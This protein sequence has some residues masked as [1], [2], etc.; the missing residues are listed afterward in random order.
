MCHSHNIKRLREKKE[1]TLDPKAGGP[2]PLLVFPPQ[3][4][5]PAVGVALWLSKP[6]CAGTGAAAVR[7]CSA[8]KLTNESRWG[9]LSNNDLQGLVSTWVWRVAT[10]V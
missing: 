10:E 6:E 8:S 3:E 4:S 5:R 1:G 9:L 7:C 2:C